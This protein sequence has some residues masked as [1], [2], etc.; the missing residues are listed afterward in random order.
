MAATARLAD[1]AITTVW[2]GGSS[3]DLSCPDPAIVC[4]REIGN[5]LSKIARFNG[6]YEGPLYSVAQHCVVGAQALI[7]EGESAM[8]AALFLLHDAHEW[9][10]GDLITPAAKLYAAV[11][12]ELYGEANVLDAIG[13]CKA[14]WDEAI[15][16]AAGLPGPEAWSRKQRA[17]VENMD[18]RM[19]LAE[20]VALFGPRAGAHFPK[21][22]TP[23]LTGAIKPWPPMKAEEEF[24]KLAYRLIGEDRVLECASIVAANRAL[25]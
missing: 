25:R 21:S 8:H 4:F 11:G 15:Y 20:A 24:R 6:R 17:T 9:I 10:L 7:N 3:I 16:F 19:Q 22:E 1:D 2:V 12:R 14:A 13:A 5:T 23:K 18:K